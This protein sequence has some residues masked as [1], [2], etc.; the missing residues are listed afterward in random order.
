[1]AQS[2]AHYD[3]DSWVNYFL[4]IDD[5]TYGSSRLSKSSN[6]VVGI[7]EAL[8]THNSNQ[9]LIFFLLN[10]WSSTADYASEGMTQAVDFEVP[11]RTE[12]A[13]YG[14]KRIKYGIP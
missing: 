11:D 9:V 6:N 14:S 13:V 7:S 12:R 2:E 5:L 3:N 4:H 10:S 1:M 8:E